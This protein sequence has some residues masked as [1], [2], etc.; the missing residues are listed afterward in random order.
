MATR[1]SSRSACITSST[2]SAITSRLT[3]EARM[4]SWPMAMASDT[5]MVLKVSGT[6]P[7]SRTP[8]LAAMASLSRWMLQGVTSFQDDATPTWGRSKSSS[9]KP[10]ARSI[11]RAGARSRPAVTSVERGRPGVL[12]VVVVISRS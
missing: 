9:V 2:E 12:E 10:T 3:S 5:V 6:A 4:P 7:A 8:A 11:D 1:P